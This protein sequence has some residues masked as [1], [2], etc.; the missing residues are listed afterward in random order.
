MGVITN[1]WEQLERA[2]IFVRDELWNATPEPR[3][4]A[5]R[6]LS[7]L[8]FSVMVAEGFI[9]DHLLLRAS[10]LAYFTVLSLIP[11]VAVVIAIVGAVGVRSGDLATLIVE[12]FTVVSPD[13]Q[14]QILELVAAA[15]F[16]GLGTIGAVSLFV[17]TVLGLSNIERA[18]NGIWGVTQQRSWGR[19]FPDY[20]AV[21][22]VAPLLLVTALSGAAALEQQWLV[23][24]LLEV[25]G[26]ALAYEVGLRHAPTIVLSVAF[27]FLYWFLPNTKVKVSAAALG[28]G[29]AGVLVLAAQKLYIGFNFGVARYDAL[30]GGF[31]ALP[32][33]FVWIYLFWAVALFGAEVAF[34]FQ[35]LA[36]YR[37]EVRGRPPGAAE[38]ESIGLR[39][40]VKV[41][42]A[43]R[44]RGEPLTAEELA[45]RMFVPVRTV[46]D[47]VAR[48][49][50]A[51][52]V[53]PHGAED[54]D[55][56][57]QLGRPAE[58]IPILDVLGAL[59]GERE[60]TTGDRDV[61]E[62]VDRVMAEI[63]EGAGKGSAGRT[64]AD[65]LAELNP[66]GDAAAGG[67]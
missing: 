64:L 4:W 52:I 32:L 67:A 2:R 17:T 35:N 53:A 6:G 44:D 5:A 11:M 10:A 8:Q 41:A 21:L 40:V 59:R 58:L 12:Q 54:Q 46:R 14:A 24:R 28:G 33:L 27:A 42:R 50:D 18:L 51:G 30:F 19:R 49:H 7:A 57:F 13:A 25:P 3:S 22:V 31:S 45:E 15:N 20:L 55:G 1:T 65:L 9:R 37:R 60:S 61:R 38:R 63:D 26:F 29:V 62:L 43:F 23:Q 48:L 39:I 36:L 56:G 66:R 16:G 47:V 34:A